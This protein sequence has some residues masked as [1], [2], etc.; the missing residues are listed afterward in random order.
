MSITGYQL[1]FGIQFRI[2]QICQQPTGLQVDEGIID[3]IG[4]ITSFV[5]F[6][7]GQLDCTG[8]DQGRCFFQQ[9]HILRIMLGVQVIEQWTDIIDEVIN[10]HVQGHGIF[11][12]RVRFISQSLIDEV[13]DPSRQQTLTV[14]QSEVFSDLLQIVGI[15]ATQQSIETILIDIDQV[16][17]SG[18]I[19][20]G[21]QLGFFS[22]TELLAENLTGLYFVLHVGGTLEVY[23]HFNWLAF[24][25]QLQ[26][27]DF[28]DRLHVSDLRMDFKS[29]GPHFTF[30]VSCSLTKIS[31]DLVLQIVHHVSLLDNAFL[32]HPIRPLRIETNIAG[33]VDHLGIDECIVTSHRPIRNLISWTG[34]YATWGMDDV[35]WTFHIYIE[36]SW[37]VIVRIENDVFSRH[38]NRTIQFFSSQHWL[39]HHRSGHRRDRLAIRLNRHQRCSRQL[40]LLYD[41]HRSWS[42][43]CSWDTIVHTSTT[44][45]LQWLWRN[46][47]HTQWLRTYCHRRQLH[48]STLDH[49]WLT[50]SLR[51]SADCWK[52]TITWLLHRN[53]LAI[54]HHCHLWLLYHHLLLRSH[55]TTRAIS[56]DVLHDRT[57]D[58]AILL[59][60]CHCCLICC[61]ELTELWL[62]RNTI[63]QIAFEHGICYFRNSHLWWVILSLSYH[64]E[65]QEACCVSRPLLPDLILE[66]VLGDLVI[67]PGMQRRASCTLLQTQTECTECQTKQLNGLWVLQPLRLRNLN[68]QFVSVWQVRVECRLVYLVDAD[69]RDI[70]RLLH[71]LHHLLLVHASS[72]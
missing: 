50:I 39:M 30:I 8:Q 45:T 9:T 13:I 63:R 38:R 21:W 54:V 34:N 6:G 36:S 31:I 40:L 57:E 72:F 15:Q 60:V 71:L 2:S 25:C 32:D 48:W 33:R 56:L 3:R 19:L 66:T 35:I 24:I 41:W 16:S 70:L 11:Q 26:F 12:E 55:S 43:L 10:I 68:R 62:S 49:L 58:L 7:T 42:R 44:G 47:L 51:A 37:G 5:I 17:T 64:Q 52:L 22:Q 61:N 18:A 1:S 65:F 67:C 46:C 69:V 20:M 29:S 53:H 4:D 28:G 14:M 27:F 23:R 59:D